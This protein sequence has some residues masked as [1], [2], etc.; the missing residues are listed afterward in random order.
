[1]TG[2]NNTGSKVPTLC[3]WIQAAPDMWLKITSESDRLPTR[4]THRMGPQRDGESPD[5][6][7]GVLLGMKL[8]LTNR[9]HHSHSP[10]VLFD[11]VAKIPEDLPGKGVDAISAG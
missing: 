4:D 3:E 2:K 11:H 5:I 10:V 1:M 6:A 9:V 7:G 8:S